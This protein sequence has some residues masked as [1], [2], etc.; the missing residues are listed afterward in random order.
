[1][2]GERH[3]AAAVVLRR[4]RV[5]LARRL[6]PPDAGLWGYPGGHVDAGETAFQAATRE[7]LEETSV[8]A[9]PLALLETLRVGGGGDEPRFRLDMVLCRYVSGEPHPADDV[10]AV[11]WVPFDQVRTAARPMSRDVETILARALACQ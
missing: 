4:G 9:V 8:S 11:E 5:L 7:L 10:S 2:Q 1:M 3:G 6:N